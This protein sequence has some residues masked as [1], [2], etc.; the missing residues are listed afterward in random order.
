MY[1]LSLYASESQQTLLPRQQAGLT[2]QSRITPL[3]NKMCSSL[4]LLSWAGQLQ[5]LVCLCVLGSNSLH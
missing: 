5:V 3:L 4:L 1:K 2:D